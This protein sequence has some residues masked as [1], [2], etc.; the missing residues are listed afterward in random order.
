MAT[1]TTRGARQRLATMATAVVALST[2]WLLVRLL[3]SHHTI[4]PEM[5]GVVVAIAGVG[6]GILSLAFLA[7]PRR[8]RVIRAVLLLLWLGVALGGIGG[9]FDHG[10]RPRPGRAPFADPRPRP[11]LAPLTFTALGI[12]GGAA[13]LVGSRQAQ[14]E[15]G[16]RTRS[17][18]P[19]GH[20][21]ETTV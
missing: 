10:R 14:S 19:I 11:P 2:V 9:Y 21:A 12:A 15:S 1:P 4:G 5:G 3:A 20:S 18:A 13:L 6:V 8:T 7:A 17:H 16:A